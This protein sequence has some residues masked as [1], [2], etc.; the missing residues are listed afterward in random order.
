MKSLRT[1]LFAGLSLLASVSQAQDMTQVRDWV[2]NL[3]SQKM[4][5]RGYVFQGAQKA[6]DFVANEFEGM[7]VDKI[8][9]Q[10]F[11][12]PVN[13]FPG[14]MSLS[15]DGQALRPGLDFLPDGCSSTL[16]GTFDA[17]TIRPDQL[18]N[19]VAFPEIIRA[20]RNKFL[21]VD[22]SSEAQ[23]P[24]E[25]Q[26]LMQSLLA[27][28]QNEN[29][30]GIAGA[31]VITDKKL[32][33]S[34]G[35]ELCWLPVIVVDKNAVGSTISKVNINLKA[36]LER[37]YEHRNVI[38]LIEGT[39]NPDET[40]VFTAH[41]DHLGGF[42]E[43][44]YF[45]GANDNASGTAMLLALAQ[46][47]AENPPEHSVVLIAFG[48]E[49]LGLLGSRHYI[50]NPLFPIN[51]IKWLINLDILGT[52]DDGIKVVNGT[53]HKEEFA[54][55]QSLNEDGG[56]LPN[57]SARGEA[58][59]SDHCFFHQREVPCFYIYTLGGIQA[60]HDPLDKAETL[61]LTGFAGVFQLITDFVTTL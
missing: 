30:Q 31:M 27:Y 46:Y 10:T 2:N 33:H 16:K 44:T 50:E 35:N 49:E 41:Y 19:Q 60:Y 43:G 58:C 7:G 24:V 36:K 3:A 56:Y 32:T 55:L 42:G 29:N 11:T 52:G 5:G 25:V 23:V 1:L 59:I 14:A 54:R 13:Q 18:T 37:E 48:A 45:P 61:P 4:Y 39:Q 53:L 9:Q 51:D 47:Y 28:L 22:V 57:I 21:I 8:F 20:A 40:V 12:S 15:I 17:Y 38:A 34:V 6:A 26:S